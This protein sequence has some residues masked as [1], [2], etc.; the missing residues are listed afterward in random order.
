MVEWRGYR[1]RPAL[2][3][4]CDFVRN[5]KFKLTEDRFGTVATLL[6]LIPVASIF[7]SFTNTGILPP[8]T[9]TSA[10]TDPL[11]VGA[12]LWAADIESNNTAMTEM[13]D[14]RSRDGKKAL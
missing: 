1:V 8:F 13:S 4:I 9:A 3:A 7:F 12:A 2:K 5:V 10:L 14:P 6:E 11:V